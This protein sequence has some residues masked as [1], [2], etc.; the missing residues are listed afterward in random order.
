M[1]RQY[2]DSLGD[3]FEAV[4]DV[5]GSD[6]RGVLRRAVARYGRGARVAADYVN[7]DHAVSLTLNDLVLVATVDGTKPNTQHLTPYYT[8]YQTQYR[9]QY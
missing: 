9:T 5:T 1:E 8:Q 2:W 6:L 3:D 4:F 7:T